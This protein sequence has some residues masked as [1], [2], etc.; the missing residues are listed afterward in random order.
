MLRCVLRASRCFVT[1][2]LIIAIIE[3]ILTL[4]YWTLIGVEYQ[5]WK[6]CCTWSCNL[7]VWWASTFI[8]APPSPVP[9]RWRHSVYCCS[10]TGV[11]RIR[12]RGSGQAYM[13]SR[14][15]YHVVSWG[16]LTRRCC[17]HPCGRCV[18]VRSY[19]PFYSC[20]K[21]G[22]MHLIVSWMW[23]LHSRIAWH[24]VGSRLS[25]HIL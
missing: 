4:H 14:E 15:H 24:L 5:L 9:P 12:Y 22:K 23:Y 3:S 6:S 18:Y 10:S 7:L 8:R 21:G 19:K 20:N 13:R 17:W 25:H 16:V 2:V 1:I 11:S